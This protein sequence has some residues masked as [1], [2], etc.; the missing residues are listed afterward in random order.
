MASKIKKPSPLAPLPQSGEG[1][2]HES[3]APTPIPSPG[4]RRGVGERSLHLRSF[5]KSLRSNQTDAE[6]KLWYHLRAKRFMNMKFRRQKPIGSYIA[7]FACTKYKLIIECDGSQHGDAHDMERDAWFTADGY[8]VLRFWN[9]QVLQQTESVLEQIQ[10]TVLA[11]N[12]PK[13]HTP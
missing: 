5:A 3:N 10:Q 1:K 11:L 13:Q 2:D 4:S 9:N 12:Y 7:D 8:T 6:L